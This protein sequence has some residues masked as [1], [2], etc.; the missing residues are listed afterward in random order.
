MVT[1]GEVDVSG[2][3]V[4]V[5]MVELG[6]VLPVVVP[7]VVP[8]VVLDMVVGRVVPSVKKNI[9]FS[10]KRKM[11]LDVISKKIILFNF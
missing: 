3:V 2:V 11:W 1:A 6:V 7:L 5:V 10:T 9:I 4:S 8:L